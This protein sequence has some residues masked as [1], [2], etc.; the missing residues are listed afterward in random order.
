MRLDIVDSLRS[1]DLELILAYG[2]NGKP[3]PSLS[4]YGER[5]SVTQ[6]TDLDEEKA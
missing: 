4:H 5:M 1:S 6:H 3:S 2:P